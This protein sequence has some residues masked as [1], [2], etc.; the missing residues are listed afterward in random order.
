MRISRF[1][2]MAA[3]V[4]TIGLAGC[5]TGGSQAIDPGT[6]PIES[7]SPTPTPTPTPTQTP[8]PT[9]T[10]TPAPTGM[11]YSLYCHIGDNYE[12]E[13]FFSDYKDAW[14]KPFDRCEVKQI[15]G[16][17]SMTEANA[18]KTAG[19]DEAEQVKYLYALCAE[20][21]GHYETDKISEGQA[22]ELKAA[23]ILCPE[24]PNSDERMKN[25]T[26]VAAAK[27]EAAAMEVDRSNGKLVSTGKYLIGTEVVPGTWQSQGVKVEDCYWEIAD[28]QGNILDNN[29][30][31]VAP[32]FTIYVPADASGFTVSGCSFRWI[33]E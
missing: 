22:G 23:L 7:A 18:I 1:L 25:M 17:P 6:Y 10:P 16:K 4:M 5:G 15:G 13:E 27:V 33:G 8:T 31:S 32:Q 19:Y 11:S 20:T 9:P 29:F 2:A 26:A 21:A 28:A 12:D 30:I 14:T 3:A 24:H